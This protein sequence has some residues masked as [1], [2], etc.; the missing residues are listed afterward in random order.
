MIHI[1]KNKAQRIAEPL[2]IS[3]YL[4]SLW[5]GVRGMAFLQKVLHRKNYKLLYEY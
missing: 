5:E 2:I 3:G 4:K 1:N